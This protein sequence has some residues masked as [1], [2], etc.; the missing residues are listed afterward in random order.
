LG[1]ILRSLLWRADPN[2]HAK[3]FEILQIGIRQKFE[4]RVILPGGTALSLY[5]QHLALCALYHPGGNTSHQVL[6]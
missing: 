3:P 2:Q 5:E 4:D 1:P 6:L